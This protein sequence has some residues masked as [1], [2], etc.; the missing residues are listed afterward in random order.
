MKVIIDLNE[1][2]DIIML[3]HSVFKFNITESKGD[4]FQDMPLDEGTCISW[5]TAIKMVRIFF[6]FSADNVTLQMVLAFF[7]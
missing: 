4:E 7:T 2:I 1:T 5:C 3:N 6:F